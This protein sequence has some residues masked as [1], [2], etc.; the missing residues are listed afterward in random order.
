MDRIAEAS[1]DELVAAEEVGEK[2]AGSILDYF[3]DPANLSLIS[4]L[5]VAGVNLQTNETG[6]ERS[7]KLQGLTFVISGTFQ[8]HSR[9]ELKSLIEQHGGRNAASV[10]AKTNYLLAGEEIGPSKLKKVEELGIPVISE[11]DFLKMIG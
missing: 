2:I 6:E 3:K 7:E 5:R 10:S 11:K 4:K 8:E 9:D 1:F